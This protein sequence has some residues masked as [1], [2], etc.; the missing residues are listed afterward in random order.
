MPPQR[1]FRCQIIRRNFEEI[2]VLNAHDQKPQGEVTNAEFHEAVQMVSQ[3]VTNEVGQQ[4]G[5]HKKRL[6]L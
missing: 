3:V 1:A 5:A 4:R 2:E 6:I